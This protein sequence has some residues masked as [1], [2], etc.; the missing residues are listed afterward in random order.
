MRRVAAP[1]LTR[2]LTLEAPTAL[3]DG[4]GGA[5]AGWVALGTL[6]AE[7]KPSSGREGVLAERAV[8][9]VTHRVAVRHAPEAS[10]R[11]PRPEQ[12]LRLG[13]RVFDVL[14]VAEHPRSGY[15]TVWAREGV[16]S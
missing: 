4:G 3:A 9:T 11:R 2:R 7:L 8:A 10:P 15:L 14:A 16:V 13:S 6:W 1:R 5:G 12:R